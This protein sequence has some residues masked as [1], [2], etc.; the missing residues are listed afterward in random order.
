MAR[1]VAISKTPIPVN[2]GSRKE[3]TANSSRFNILYQIGKDCAE[4]MI[5]IPT[6]KVKLQVVPNF[7]KN[8]NLVGSALCKGRPVDCA[9]E[10]KL[11]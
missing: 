2:Q 8:P 10:S 9:K 3:T 5:D 1:M 7:S 4:E 6:F 11:F